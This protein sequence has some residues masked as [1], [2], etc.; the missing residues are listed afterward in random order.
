MNYYEKIIKEKQNA[1]FKPHTPEEDMRILQA[2]KPIVETF[3]KK[4]MSA[5]DIVLRLEKEPR[6]T[7]IL[8]RQAVQAFY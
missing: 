6:V 7:A 1:L 4:G 5:A 3:K 8:A 2:L